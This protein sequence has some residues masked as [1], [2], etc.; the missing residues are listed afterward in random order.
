M[1]LKPT[2]KTVTANKPFLILAFIAALL[3]AG[4]GAYYI[5]S[6]PASPP[7]QQQTSAAAKVFGAK[8]TVLDNGL[9]VVVVENSRVPAVTHMVWYANGAADENK[10][11]SGTAHFLEHLMFK[12]SGDLAPG[13]FSRIVKTLGGN[14][15]AFTSQDYTAYYQSV[16]ADHLKTVMRMEAGRMRGLSPPMEEVASEHLVVLEERRQRTDN[17]PDAQLY[18]QLRYAL[19]PNHPYGAPIIGWMHEM[20][21]LSWEAAKHYYDAWYHPNNAILIVTG[22]VTASDVFALAEEIYGAIPAAD[23]PERERPE[24]PPLPADTHLS[25]HHQYVEQPE[26]IRAY[27]VPS[28]RQSKEES[29]ALQVLEEIMGGGSTSRLY[30][31]LVVEQKLATNV[32]LS[33]RGDAWDYAMLSIQASPAPGADMTTLEAAIDEQLA[34]LL[35]EGITDK[36][37]SDAINRLENEAIY[38]RDSLSGPALI[39]GYGLITG[40]SLDDIEYWPRDIAAVTAAQVQKAAASYLNPDAPFKHPPVTGYLLP[41]KKAKEATP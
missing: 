25:M 37:L 8:Q 22:D 26:L 20:E 13:E 35:R 33:Y 19:F 28:A 6:L 17:N 7:A 18:E 31:A 34:K 11:E 23:L 10:G 14:D 40:S 38:A 3:L 27:V 30:R 29:L 2:A 21:A 24:M 5:H 41:A 39:I 4:A 12:G 1:K 9:R 16:P 36:E 32:S 15:N